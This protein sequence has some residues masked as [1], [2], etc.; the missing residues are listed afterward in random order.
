MNS[1][2][3]LFSSKVLS[4]LF[5]QKGIL[6]SD[7]IVQSTNGKEI[8]LG[9]FLS[10]IDSIAIDLVETGL[11]RGEKVLF[12]AQPSIESILYIFAVL[13]AG[14]VLVVADPRMG[15]ENFSGRVTFMKPEYVLVDENLDILSKIPFLRLLLGFFK[16]IPDI[17]VL[18]QVKRIVIRKP[19]LNVKSF[20]EEYIADDADSI[21]I[22]TSGT[23]GVPKGVVHSNNSLFDTLDKIN[24]VLSIKRGDIFYSSQ[25]H[26]ILASIIFGAKAV[27]PKKM[28]VSTKNLY[29]DLVRFKI[30]K[31]F[32]VPSEYMDVIDFCCK[33]KLKLPESLGCLILGS[34]PVL[35]GFL[36]KLRMI[37]SKNTDVVAIYGA[38]E[39][40]PIAYVRMTDKLD[41]SGKGDLLGELVE[42]VEVHIKEGEIYA[43]GSGLFSRYFGS[44]NISEYATG[45]LGMCDKDKDLVLFGRKKDMII[46]RNYNIYPSIF[47]S[48]ISKIQGVRN[49]ALVGIYDNAV[50]DEKVYLVVEKDENLLE[51]EP[52]FKKRIFKELCKGECS[53]D[54]EALPDEIVFMNLPVNG[55][56][57][58]IDKVR[59]RSFISKY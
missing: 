44:E 3:N 15:R 23:T 30:T 27:F 20:H 9:T 36:L 58:K 34:A 33:K 57:K 51:R 19:K 53:I 45:D 52:H 1:Q 28:E 13:R 41:F 22:F 50:N 17:D 40:L 55:R 7:V 25:I 31:T 42:G 18:N 47:E 49:C 24:T 29:K 46:R 32:G 43:S 16:S 59:I 2:I 14:G 11:K 21:I 6:D 48:T 12:L 10:Y 37:L 5:E 4:K 8:E 56:S 39:I 35:K 54:R 38:T 26:F